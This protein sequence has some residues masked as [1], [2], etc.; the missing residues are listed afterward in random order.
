MATY[1]TR[2]MQGITHLCVAR[3]QKFA[4]DTRV[5]PCTNAHT[6]TLNMVARSIE[7]ALSHVRA[8]SSLARAISK[9]IAVYTCSFEFSLVPSSDNSVFKRHYRILSGLSLG[10]LRECEHNQYTSAEKRSH[11]LSSAFTT[12]LWNTGKSTLS[13]TRWKSTTPDLMEGFCRFYS[14]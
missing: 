6:H 4:C 5:Q 2:Q 10:S 11:L 7:R 3:M 12:C 14:D 9:S 1:S 13:Q 8:Q